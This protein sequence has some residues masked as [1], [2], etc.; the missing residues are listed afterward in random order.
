MTINL[1]LIVKKIVKVDLRFWREVFS[2]RRDIFGGIFYLAGMGSFSRRD[3]FFGG[4]MDATQKMNYF[5]IFKQG[6]PGGYIPDHGGP[7]HQP[8]ASNASGWNDPPPMMSRPSLNTST[9]DSKQASSGFRHSIVNFP[10]VDHSVLPLML[11]FYLIVC[12]QKM[13]ALKACL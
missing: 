12:L 2:H 4:K 11:Y 6:P 13:K 5:V 9:T 1:L 10:D 3:H 7:G 8:P